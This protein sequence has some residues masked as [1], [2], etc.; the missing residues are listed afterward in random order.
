MS[1]AGRGGRRNERAAQNGKTVGRPPK[2]D[3]LVPL[4]LRVP[5]DL[6]AAYDAAPPAVRAQA[7]AAMVTALVAAL[8]ERES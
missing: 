2:P 4:M 5:P 1:G 6:R 3:K 7:R 8:E